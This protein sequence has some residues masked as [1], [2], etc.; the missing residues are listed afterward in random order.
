[1]KILTDNPHVVV[2]DLKKQRHKKSGHTKSFDD[3]RDT[4][5]LQPQY[6]CN[7]C[8]KQHAKRQCPAYGQKCRKCG[9]LNHFAKYCR[10]KR[11]VQYV[12]SNEKD[13]SDN[14][15]SLQYQKQTKQNYKL[16][17]DTQHWMLRLYLSNSKL[18]QEL[19]LTYCRCTHSIT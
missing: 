11:T 16:T 12:G 7:N 2:D 5:D 3:K 17:S 8:E 15:L 19:R 18:T 9:K 14:Q 6:T 1:M 10:S 4:K 13:D